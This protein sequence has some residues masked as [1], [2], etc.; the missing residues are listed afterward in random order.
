MP[1]APNKVHVYSMVSSKTSRDGTH[2]PCFY[3][4]VTPARVCGPSVC[5]VWMP[6]GE[7]LGSV[8]VW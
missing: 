8:C 3:P 6:S 7:L 2:A 4:L 1:H 5:G